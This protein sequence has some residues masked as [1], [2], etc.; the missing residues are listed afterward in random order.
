MML[1][2][3]GYDAEIFGLKGSKLV[4]MPVL[5]SLPPFRATAIILA[6]WP[7]VTLPSGRK[8]PSS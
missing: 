4:G 7:R 1:V 2:A 3:L 5:G 6:I 8:E